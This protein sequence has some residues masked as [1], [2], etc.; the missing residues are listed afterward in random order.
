M[1]IWFILSCIS[2]QS[3]PNKRLRLSA[4]ALWNFAMFTLLNAEPV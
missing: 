2:C 4:L 1:L 3:C